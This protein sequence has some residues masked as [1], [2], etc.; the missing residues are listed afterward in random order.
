[1]CLC[2][3]LH[4]FLF[5]VKLTSLRRS[6]TNCFLKV[7]P[8]YYMQDTLHNLLLFSKRKRQ[9]R[10]YS[11]ISRGQ[12]RIRNSAKISWRERPATKATSFTIMLYIEPYYQGKPC[13]AH[14]L[15]TQKSM[16]VRLASAKNTSWV[17]GQ[18]SDFRGTCP[19]VYRRC[20]DFELLR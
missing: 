19:C 3:Y 2:N 11:A 7:F 15:F 9:Q 20:G 10:S 17:L 6:N 12:F 18:N 5:H 1:M 4:H 13:I 8:R 16:K 14:L